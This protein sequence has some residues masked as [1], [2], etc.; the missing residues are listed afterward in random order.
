MLD[1]ARLFSLLENKK[2]YASLLSLWIRIAPMVQLLFI[3]L[4][5]DV[6]KIESELHKPRQHFLKR[7]KC[8][9]LDIN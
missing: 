5:Y 6:I 3:Y 2:K 8:L 7:K 4:F 1:F 9:F